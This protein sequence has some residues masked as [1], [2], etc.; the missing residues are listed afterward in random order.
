MFLWSD[1]FPFV[2]EQLGKPDCRMVLTRSPDGDLRAEL[3][4]RSG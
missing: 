4:S 2:L 1:H 3:I